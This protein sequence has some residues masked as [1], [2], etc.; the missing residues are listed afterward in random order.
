MIENVLILSKK[1]QENNNNNNNTMRQ[2]KKYM[3]K[4]K[5][6]ILLYQPFLIN[7]EVYLY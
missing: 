4:L 3:A 6:I 2:H 7:N 5:G 1:V